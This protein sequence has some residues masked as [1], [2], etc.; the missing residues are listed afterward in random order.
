MKGQYFASSDRTI[1]EF[2]NNYTL[3]FCYIIENKT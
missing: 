2:L 1:G 3:T